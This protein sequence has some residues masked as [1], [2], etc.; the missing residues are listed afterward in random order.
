MMNWIDHRWHRCDRFSQIV[1]HVN[2]LCQSVLSV[3]SVG[4][5]SCL[6]L[7]SRKIVLPLHKFR[8]HS[9]GVRKDFTEKRCY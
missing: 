5:F 7:S 1:E 3:S 4:N 8:R 6:Y 9:G 2:N